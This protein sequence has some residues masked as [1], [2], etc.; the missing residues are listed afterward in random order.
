MK[1]TWIHNGFAIV[2]FIVII[3]GAL[4]L[5]F[6][7]SKSSDSDSNES[8]TTAPEAPAI[9]PE[10]SMRVCF[11]TFPEVDIEARERPMTHCA[12]F[13]TAL[14]HI[15]H[16]RRMTRERLDLPRRAFMLARS[17]PRVYEGDSTFSWTFGV[18]TNNIRLTARLLPSDSI[19]WIMTVTNAKLDSFQWY[20]GR[21]CRPPTG[22]WWQY[23]SPDTT[24]HPDSNMIL[25]TG[26]GKDFHDTTAHFTLR[27]TNVRDT[28]HYGD[29]L[30]Y[31]I[32]Y[33]MSGA[34][35]YHVSGPRPGI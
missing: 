3:V 32:D 23:Y 10:S 7:C 29:S 1:I 34:L 30:R 17:Q 6:A 33:P 16:W 15:R 9:P 27:N 4:F 25:W 28:L 21:C 12:D 2:L 19:E 20:D 13:D 24:M 5:G 14:R 26:W 35:L 22:G 18:D 31:Q 8:D 11:S